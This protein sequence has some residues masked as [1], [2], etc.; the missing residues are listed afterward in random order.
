M[1]VLMSDY[2]QKPYLQEQVPV[3]GSMTLVILSKHMKTLQVFKAMLDSDQVSRQ[4]HLVPV[5][6]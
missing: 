1:F 3:F 4:S 6:L 5:H 2:V